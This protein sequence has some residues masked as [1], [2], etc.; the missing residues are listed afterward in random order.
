[1]ID[2]PCPDLPDLEVTITQ[3]IVELLLIE[4]ERRFP[5][6][7]LG[8]TED[9]TSV[10]T[11][12]HYARALLAY[13]ISPES[14]ALR[15]IIDWFDQPFPQRENDLIDPQEM[16]RLIILLLARPHKDNV[17]SRLEHLSGQEHD[18]DFD[19]QPG[20]GAFDTLWALE[21]FSLA[22]DRQVLSPRYMTEDRLKTHLERLLNNREMR[23]VKDVALALRLQHQ[24]FGGLTK[25]HEVE[26][27]R[28]VKVA[29][30]NRGV[31]GMEEIGWLTQRMAWVDEFVHGS[32]LLPQEVREYQDPF[33]RVVL[34][35]CMVIENLAPL[36]AAY[37]EI[38]PTLD[39]AMKL[40]W[41]QFHGRH[42]IETLRNLFPKP[43]DFD[44]LRV[45]CR[46]LRAVQ[47]YAGAPLVDLNT[48]N[49]HLLHELAEM[50]KDLSESL[51]VRNI[52]AALR[53]WLRIDLDRE[54]EP[55]KLGFS[56]ANV[57][58]VYPVIWSPLTSAN[59]K[60]VTFP[61]ESVIIKYG[62]RSEIEHERNNYGKLPS[63]IQDH[64]VRIPETTYTD[65]QTGLAYVVMQ[66]LHDYKTLYE[67][68]SLLAR[69]VVAVADQLGNFLKQMHEGGTSVT[70]PV[71]K[72]L[73]REI[74]LRKMMEYI[75]RIFDFVWEYKV[76]EKTQTFVNEIQ[77]ELFDCIGEL[78][79]QQ[80][81]IRDFPAAYM[82]G[83]LHLRNIMIRGADDAA[84]TQNRGLNFRLIDLEYLT[85]E[86]DAAF[87]AGQLLIDI[88]LVSR[89]E[90]RFDSQRRLASLGEELEIVYK[91][92][93]EAR[94]D[95]TF[96]LRVELAKARALL[97][98]AKGKTKRGS[99]Y[100]R[101]RQS[102]QADQMAEE[103]ISHAAE[104]LTYMQNVMS[105]LK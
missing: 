21:A 88:D 65:L 56:E 34:S 72:S 17:Q 83:D 24:Y 80:L 67:V 51:E 75:D 42:A 26:L 27:R 92:F 7:I 8:N 30:D 11:T 71:T 69:D 70:R 64:F 36:Q 58:R 73:L 46:T 55:L 100:L 98:I 97:R 104:A 61:G 62:P 49:V 87:D 102:A 105:K 25:K 81:A 50:K 9:K 99:K 63:G 96:N 89:E 76:F 94:N 95:A 59:H 1:M 39:C 13:G 48:V 79:R 47:A 35:T 3:L 78:I 44:Y 90:S 18:G 29:N 22:Q 40:W 74:Y 2:N 93:G 52:K 6:L 31:W 14:D 16:N 4:K 12:L 57:V 91:K 10:R 37:P 41:T 54:V 5:Q 28:L 38:V 15:P 43:Y 103:V 53:S 82:H 23:K 32:R 101:E 66:D 60:A 19:V 20:W 85:P 68:H 77:H 84:A 33:R 86:G 45:V